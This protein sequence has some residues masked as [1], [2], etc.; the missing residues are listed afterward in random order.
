[1]EGLGIR[2]LF[3]QR[4]SILHG[5][6]YPL[7]LWDL[8]SRSPPAMTGLVPPSV[9]VLEEAEVLPIVSW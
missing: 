2:L 5:G 9:D 8:V 4:Q 3:D 6:A 7:F 1:M